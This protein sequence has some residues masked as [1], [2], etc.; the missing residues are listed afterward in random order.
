MSYINFH[1]HSQYSNIA[2]PDVVITN[3]DRIRRAVELGH[4]V[5]SGVEHGWSGNFFEFVDLCKEHNIKP[6]LGT[7]AYFV[8]D[9][10]EK[11]R[12]NA[13]LILLAKNE[14][15]RKAINRIVS[16]ANVS[17]FYYKARVDLELLETLP[18]NDVWV[19]TACLGGI[20]KYD[21]AE[22]LMIWMHK[23]FKDNFYL[24]VQYHH[25][26]KQKLVNKKIL[27]LSNKYNIPIIAGLD[28]HMISPRGAEK[29]D[30]FLASRGIV[31][32]DES[33]WFLDFP[34]SRTVVERFRNQ[35]ILTEKQIATAIENTNVFNEVKVYDSPIFDK[36]RIKLPTIYPDLNQ[37]EKNKIFTDLIY[38]Q[39]D[40][41][42]VSVD[43]K[44][45]QE[46]KDA[47]A[48]ELDTVVTTGM[49]DYF[50]LNYEIIK[51]AKKKGGQLTLTSRGSAPGFYLSKLLEFTTIDRLSSKVK[52]YPERFISKERILE[53]KSLPDVDFNVGNPEVF[54]EAQTKIM[55]RDHAYR[56]I[57]YQKSGASNAWKLY[58]RF[59]EIPFNEANLVSSQIKEY[60]KALKY[61]ETDDDKDLVDINDFVEQKYI[62]EYDKSKDFLGT[63]QSLGSHPCAFLLLDSGKLDEEIGLIRTRG[64]E[65]CVA[66]DGKTADKRLFLK[67]DLLKVT[68]V[69]NILETYGRI[70]I[71]PHTV[72]ELLE[73]CEED[74]KVWSMYKRG[75]TQGLNQVETVSTSA[76]VRAYAPENIS[77]LAS[78]V[79]AIRPGFKSNYAQYARREEFSYGI[80][81]IDNLIQ[82]EEFPFSYMLY[83]ENAMAILGYAGIPM[84]ETYQVV[85][86]IAKKNHK[87]IYRYE[88]IFKPLLEKKLI[89][90][91]KTPRKE[92]VRISEM[93]W[94]IIKDSARYSFNSSHSYSVASDSLYGAWQKAH[95][96]LAFYETLLRNYEE[97]S[98]KDKI[99]LAK[100]E[101]E[102]HFQVHFPSFKWGQDNRTIVANESTNSITM[103]L[104][105]IKGFGHK[106]AQELYS[107]HKTFGGETFL[108]LLIFAEEQGM[109]SKSKW[110]K[111]IRINYFSD[112][113]GAVRIKKIF[114]EFIKGKFRYSK[115][116][117]DKTKE[118]RLPELRMLVESIPDESYL[119]R[120]TIQNEVEILGEV[121]TR[122]KQIHPAFT[123]VAKVED[124][125]KE[126]SPKVWLYSL[127]NGTQPL[128]K[129]RKDVWE[130]PKNRLKVGD[131][132]FGLEFKRDTKYA[133]KGLKDNG[134][135]DFEP[136]EGTVEHWMEKHKVV[137]QPM[138]DF[139][140]FYNVIPKIV[141]EQQA[142]RL[143]ISN[144]ITSPLISTK[145]KK[146]KVDWK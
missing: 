57:T 135:P 143:L 144:K 131:I 83:Q 113:G 25:T 33:G 69:K 8:K 67:N 116:H 76:K 137:S 136:I 16:E 138:E 119:I 109:L 35:G 60:D 68:V 31:Y 46:Y 93:I 19:T 18:E 52:L 4:T 94:K 77:E 61:A 47:I 12:T 105:T 5:V 126:I 114:D 134:K 73:I 145:P 127:A 66:V 86:N 2:T 65:I 87:E 21:D 9:R 30:I 75:A 72:D 133:F 81:P 32:E 125:S 79:A 14:N 103:S 89:E 129:F 90:T 121:K 70:G 22:E 108:D 118:K 124:A 10:L 110:M 111:M 6:L 23:K 91:E 41:E 17:G 56:M 36:D 98:K 101:A 40:K 49:A 7:E 120:E 141:A 115:K 58:A 39:W 54:E 97:D 106:I 13:H 95:H 62:K 26:L 59:A 96:H 50:L 43:Q 142:Q 85:K 11:D 107:L 140:D 74:K 132:V 24:E 99:I 112:F 139:V 82:T 102:R 88:S 3:E 37:D 42:K 27:D 34:S 20:W 117:T 28:S 53:T 15:G 123:I 80:P 104:S 48:F 92:A 51:E 78:F 130:A 146:R 122:F 38:S 128:V 44:R 64:N 45:I 63:I 1:C 71:K 29:R 100:V 55:G 84:Y